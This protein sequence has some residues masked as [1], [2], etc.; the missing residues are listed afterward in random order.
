MINKEISVTQDGAV[1]SGIVRGLSPEGA[2]ILDAGGTEKT[3][4]AGDVTILGS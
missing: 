2:L 4:F 3:L 1:I